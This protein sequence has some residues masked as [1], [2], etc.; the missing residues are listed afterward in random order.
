MPKVFA[1]LEAA[2]RA[3]DHGV[4]AVQA[5]VA[6]SLCCNSSASLGSEKYEHFTTGEIKKQQS[7]GGDINGCGSAIGNST[8]IFES[9]ALL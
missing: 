8:A 6:R 1:L 2:G 7:T 9:V 5:V 4:A 3:L